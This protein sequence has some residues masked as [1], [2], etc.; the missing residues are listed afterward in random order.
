MK[1]PTKKWLRE[2]VRIDNLLVVADTN[3]YARGLRDGRAITFKEIN[4][5]RERRLEEMRGRAIDAMAH[6]LKAM[7]DV[8][9]PGR[10]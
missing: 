2:K 5:S 7:G 1:R 9:E 10:I 8:I 3:G 4:D 6:A